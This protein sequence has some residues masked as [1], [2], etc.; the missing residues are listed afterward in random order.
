MQNQQKSYFPDESTS[1]RMSASIQECHLNA[2][3][4]P[5][6]CLF[7]IFSK[8]SSFSF[9]DGKRYE[10]TGKDYFEKLTMCKA[11]ICCSK[12]T[13]NI[14]ENTKKYSCRLISIL[15]E[16]IIKLFAIH[17]T[18]LITC[19]KHLACSIWFLDTSESWKLGC[20]VLKWYIRP[21]TLELVIFCYIMYINQSVQTHLFICQIVKFRF[22]KIY[23]HIK[24]HTRYFIKIRDLQ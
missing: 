7:H 23:S 4:P 15:T 13:T 20:P 17:L 16:V 14:I 24:R 11:P 12:Y 5:F 6:S 1:F 2:G 3:R 10:K 9:C 8:F 19:S 18:F 21:F 22:N